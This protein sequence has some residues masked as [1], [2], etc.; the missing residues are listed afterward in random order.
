MIRII[1]GKEFKFRD[2]V[3]IKSADIKEISVLKDQ[4]A[5]ELYGEK[6]KNGVVLVTLKD[7]VL[8]VY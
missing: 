3:N 8:L 7:E 5:I 1:N 4:K 2:F 6:G